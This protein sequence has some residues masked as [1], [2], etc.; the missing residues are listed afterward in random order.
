MFKC[1]Y[2]HL[3]QTIKRSRRVQ[4]C[5]K[6]LDFTSEGSNGQP[7]CPASTLSEMLGAFTNLRSFKLAYLDFVYD[8][9][10]FPETHHPQCHGASLGSV[11]LTNVVGTSSYRGQ[12]VESGAAESTGL[13]NFLSLFDSIQVLTIDNRALP[14]IYPITWHLLEA[15]PV[16]CPRPILLKLQELQLMGQLSAKLLGALEGIVDPAFLSTLSVEL[17]P[18]VLLLVDRF[19]QRMT[20]L[21]SIDFSIR[22]DVIGTTSTLFPRLQPCSALRTLH[23]TPPSY[24]W[25]RE[26][27]SVNARIWKTVVDIIANAPPSLQAVHINVRMLLPDAHAHRRIDWPSLG[28]ALERLPRLEIAEL[29][30]DGQFSWSDE[31]KAVVLGGQP[32]AA[33]QAL[34]FT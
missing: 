3:S 1:W 13:A 18:A 31:M 26:G 4:E 24:H 20:R 25:S 8:I 28:A 7:A 22:A 14:Y 34:R 30:A 10:P 19:L 21:Q 27:E 16:P 11:N 5:V 23:I 17:S 33:Q 6:S 9:S 2:Q 15:T 29:K 32:R 12:V